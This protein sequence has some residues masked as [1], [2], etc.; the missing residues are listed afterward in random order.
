MSANT[1]TLLLAPFDKFLVPYLGF[2]SFL[3]IWDVGTNCYLPLHYCMHVLS[4]CICHR[5]PPSCTRVL[6]PFNAKIVCV[7]VSKFLSMLFHFGTLAAIQC[8]F[9]K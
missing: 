5:G 1:Q 8:P 6:S 9:V 7:Q 3:C 4:R 2:F